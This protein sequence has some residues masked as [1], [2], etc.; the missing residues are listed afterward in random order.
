MQIPIVPFFKSLATSICV[1]VVAGIWG[2]LGVQVSAAHAG[3]FQVTT[4]VYSGFT[5]VSGGHFGAGGTAP[6]QKPGTFVPYPAPG[7]WQYPP[8]QLFAVAMCAGNG[9]TSV[10]SDTAS[11]SGSVTY[12]VAWVPSGTNDP[13]PSNADVWVRESGLATGG[14]YVG[15]SL[16][17]ATTSIDGENVTSI[18][19]LVHLKISGGSVTKTVSLSASVTAV[20]DLGSAR[21]VIASVSFNASVDPR[22]LYVGSDID[23]SYTRGMGIDGHTPGPYQKANQRQDDGSMVGDTLAPSGPLQGNSITYSALLGGNWGSNPVYSW[24]SEKNNSHPTGNTFPITYNTTNAPPDSSDNITLTV[25]DPRD[26]VS[27]KATYKM[28][29]H[30]SAQ[31]L[32]QEPS[33]FR[34]RYDTQPSSG[35]TS[36]TWVYGGDWTF[37]TSFQGPVLASVTAAT[38]SS[39][40]GSLTGSWLNYGGAGSYMGIDSVMRSLASYLNFSTDEELTFNLA[41]SAP[42]SIPANQIAYAYYGQSYEISKHRVA[43]WGYR[44]YADDLIS[45]EIRGGKPAIMHPYAIGWLTG[46]KLTSK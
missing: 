24:Q 13:A 38:P 20:A 31:I 10:I 41:S 44:G 15:S 39:R 18:N 4:K 42:R 46:N 1:G 9:G 8:P 2:C 17:L 26:G 33:E 14:P 32:G 25:T 45:E 5:S 6:W 7:Y 43:A 21:S 19:R 34:P 40:K 27:A 29:F 36:Q 35:V 3:S 22:S 12:T 23:T 16:V 30:T 28:T 37:A 11:S